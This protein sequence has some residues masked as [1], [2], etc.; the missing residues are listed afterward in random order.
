MATIEVFLMVI[1]LNEVLFRFFDDFAVLCKLRAVAREVSLS[2]IASPFVNQ[3]SKRGGVVNLALYK[4]L[5]LS[6]ATSGPRLV[7][8]MYVRQVFE[9]HDPLV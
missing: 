4:G 2:R 9:P 5:K 6:Q 7:N 8:N 3:K 1:G